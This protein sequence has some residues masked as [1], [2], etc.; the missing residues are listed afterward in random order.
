M[1]GDGAGEELVAAFARW[2]ADQRAGT[3]A[4]DRA[5]ERSLRDQAGG[6][7]DLGRASWSIWPSRPPR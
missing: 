4:A 7:G 2:A 5:R 6:H 1:S 3:A